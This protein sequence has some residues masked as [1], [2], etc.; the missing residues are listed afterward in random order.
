M[1]DSRMGH[2]SVLYI[3]NGPCAQQPV[4]VIARRRHLALPSRE[5]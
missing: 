3:L 4:F 2:F 1:G 5:F